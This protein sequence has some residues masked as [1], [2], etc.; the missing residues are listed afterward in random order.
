MQLSNEG[1]TNVPGSH[2]GTLNRLTESDWR[3][4]DSLPL[5]S[6]FACI[7]SATARP[8]AGPESSWMKCDPD[9][10]ISV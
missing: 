4:R 7:Q 10:V 6:E 2:A 3:S 5:Y 8:I 9:T 1:L